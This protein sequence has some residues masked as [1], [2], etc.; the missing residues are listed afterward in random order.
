MDARLVSD[1][2]YAMVDIRRMVSTLVQVFTGA[3]GESTM[4]LAVRISLFT[5]EL[6]NLTEVPVQ[7]ARQSRASRDIV[8]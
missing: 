3:L 4:L 7:R 5:I 1:C 6:A 2:R 8:D